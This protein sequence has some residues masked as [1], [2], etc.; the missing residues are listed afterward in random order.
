[1]NLMSVLSSI[2]KKTNDI[3]V[4]L[5]ADTTFADLKMDSYAIVE[6]VMGVEETFGIVFDSD[7]IFELETIQDVMN[8]IE[9]NNQEDL[10]KC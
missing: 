7:K 9:K 4:E 10:K 6:F 2:L 8:L 3:S 5:K 1:M